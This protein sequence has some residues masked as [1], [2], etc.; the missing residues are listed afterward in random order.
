MDSHFWNER[1]LLGVQLFQ[2]L[3]SLDSNMLETF[4]VK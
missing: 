1:F 3:M 2:N 4:L